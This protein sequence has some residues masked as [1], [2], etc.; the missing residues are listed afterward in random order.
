MAHMAVVVVIM[1]SRRVGFMAVSLRQTANLS[2]G[3][4]SNDATRCARRA[5][6]RGM[7][8]PPPGRNGF[9]LLGETLSFARN[10]FRFVEDRLARHGRIFRSHVLGRKTAV[11]AG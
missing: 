7:N 8:P 3:N 1:N 5:Y 10:P 2:R 9:P 6:P 4:R 11:V